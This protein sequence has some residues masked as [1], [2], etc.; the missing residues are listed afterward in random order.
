MTNN[1]ILRSVRFILN[2]NEL[3]LAEII[4]LADFKVSSEEV[5]SFL[6]QEYEEGYRIC[7]E[8]MLAR[9]LDGLVIL[10]RGKNENAPLQRLDVSLTNNIILKKLRV[11]FQLKDSDIIRLIDQAGLKISKAELGAFFRNPDH[12]NYRDC[13]NQFLRNLLRGMAL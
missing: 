12:R 9:F 8:K 10:K 13:G 1:D 6:K 4:G 5:S 3:K 11:A 7:S 2:V